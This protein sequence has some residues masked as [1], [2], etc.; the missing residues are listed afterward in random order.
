MSSANQ[1]PA[2]TSS[3]ASAVPISKGM[4]WTG[5]VLSALPVA[6]MVFSAVLK[7]LK[8]AP[9]VESFAHFGYPES[10]I[11]LLGVLEL[12]S[13]IVY[14][15]PRTAVLGAI[16]MTGYLGGATATNVRVGDHSYIMTVTLGVLVWAG[17]FLRDARVRALIPLRG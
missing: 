6:L 15:I 13:C 1:S 4:I 2:T 12:L 11:F 3:A 16:L 8:P 14:V 9:V 17:L 5:R 7:F 10:E